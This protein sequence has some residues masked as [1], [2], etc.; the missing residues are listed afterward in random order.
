VAI[1]AESIQDTVIDV[2]EICRDGARSFASA[3]SAIDSDVFKKEL[4]HYSRERAEFAEAL[5]GVLEELGYSAISPAA[6]PESKHGGWFN[7]MHLNPNNN[8]HAIL[9]ACER[10]E[11]SAVEAYTE[12]ISAAAPSPVGELISAQYQ[13]VRATHERIRDLRDTAEYY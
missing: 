2:I 3:A 1:V 9:S 10:S 11:E 8:V 5:C 4:L 6:V 7:S 13:V 12:A